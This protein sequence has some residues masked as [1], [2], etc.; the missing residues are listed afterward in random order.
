M[1]ARYRIQDDRGECRISVIDTM[2]DEPRAE[3][4][5]DDSEGRAMYLHEAAVECAELN[6]QPASLAIAMTGATT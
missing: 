5:Y 4:E 6:G 1:T 3:Y 2:T